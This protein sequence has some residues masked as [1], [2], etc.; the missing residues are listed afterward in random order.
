MKLADGFEKAFIGSTI[1]AFS[2]EQVALYDYDLCIKV[3]VEDQKM[4]E[5][6]AIEYFDYNVIGSWVGEDTPIFIHRHKIENVEDYL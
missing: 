6:E 5:E 2:R 3:L 1:S 4:T